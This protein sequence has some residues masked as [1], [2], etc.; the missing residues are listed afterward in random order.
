MDYK[1]NSPKWYEQHRLQEV[2]W[3]QQQ[4]REQA[5]RERLQRD[6]ALMRELR[7]QERQEQVEQARAQARET[8]RNKGSHCT[9]L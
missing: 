1:R 4:L 8:L 7:E 6:E 3:Q 9:K 2:Q 5:E